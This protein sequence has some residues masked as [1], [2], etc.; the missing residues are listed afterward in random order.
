[1]N[2]AAAA[3]AAVSFP[4]RDGR[5][6]HGLLVAAPAAPRAALV[7]NAATG[8]GREFYLKFAAYAAQRGYHTLLH[9]YRG[10]GRSAVNPLS[11]ET[12]TMSEWGL[13]DMP[14]AL[15]WLLNRY[16]GLPCFT[17]GHSVGGQLIGCMDNANRARAHLM[18]AASTGYWRRE[19]IPFRFLALALW[20]LYGPLMLALRGYLPQGGLWT[21]RA[22]PPGVFRQW[23]KWCLSAAPFPELDE[24]LQGSHFAAVRGPVL[25]LA[26]T[27][28]PIATPAAV[29]ALLASYSAARIE[30]RWIRPA[31]A[32]VRSLGHRGFFAA[33]HRDSLWPG[34]FDWLDARCS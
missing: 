23:R 9:D 26:F 15:D 16:P 11:A 3:P 22:L 17:V 12:A 7:V 2:T 8:V 33:R 19:S 25:A 13:L 10:M 4:A 31:D 20:W 29:T 21:G 27:D 24:R 6:L 18:V 5:L 14:A 34:V 32:G 1:M 30:Q 28:D